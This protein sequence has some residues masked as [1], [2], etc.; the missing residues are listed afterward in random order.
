MAQNKWYC[1]VVVVVMSIASWDFC[2]V[3]YVCVHYSH[4]C[5]HLC[6]P[7]GLHLGMYFLLWVL[8]KKCLKTTQLGQFFHLIDGETDPRELN[9]LVGMY[10]WWPK[11][12]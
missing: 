7:C 1:V 3:V 11:Q 10:A 9:D 12:G 5:V 2:F 4:R 8:L 6:V